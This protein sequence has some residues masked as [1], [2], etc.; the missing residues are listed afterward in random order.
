MAS[1]LRFQHFEVLTRAD[2]SPHLL[3]KGAMGLTY[4][5]FDRNL[6]SFAVV[7]V[8]APEHAGRPEARQRFLQEAQSMARINH[9]N[10]ADVFFLGESAQGVFYAMEFCDG[11]S[12]QEYVEEHGPMNPADVFTLGQQA[13][14]ALRAVQRNNLIHRDIKPSNMILVNDAQ[15]RPQIKL[16]DFGL[17]RD[18]VTNPDLS[19]GGF[20]GTPT[21]ASPEQ[22][23]EQEGLDIRSDIYSLGITLW[24]MLCGRAPFS[25]S[26]FEVMFHHVNT[27]PPWDRLPPL[28]P[29]AVALLRRMIEKSPEERYQNPDSLSEAFQTLLAAGGFAVPSSGLLHFRPRELEGSVLGMSSFEILSESPDSDLT[30]KIF[31]ARDAHDGR[32]IS[33]KYL[34]P[35]IVEKVN[36]LGKIQRHVL[37]LRALKHPNL[38]EILDFEKSESGAQIISEWVYGPSLLSLLKARNHLTLAEA[39]PLLGQL[40]SALD[41]AGSRG[42]GTV[43]T[44]LHQ[45]FLTSPVFGDDPA[46]WPKLLRQPLSSWTDLA[47]KVNPL[48][49]SPAAQDYPTIAQP[50]PAPELTGAPKPLLG[51]FLHLV[52]RLLGGA[53]GSQSGSSAG[54]VSIPGLGA[55]AND[56]IESFG[57]PPFTP[58]KRA[59]TA[60]TVLVGLCQAEGVREPDIYVPPPEP[61]E[62]LMLTRDAALKS[63]PPQQGSTFAR[64][65]T[66][67]GPPSTQ[68][69]KFAPPS[70]SGPGSRFGGP[71]TQ[72]GAPGTQFG[73]QSR[74]GTKYGSSGGGSSAGRISAD[75]E[76]KRKELELQRQR[77]ESEAER[78]KQEEVLE[79]TRA[80]LDEERS[81]LAEAKDEFARQERDRAQRAE[82]ER[83]KLEEERLRLE[84]K[85]GEV[86]VKRREQERLEQEIKLRAQLEFQKFE[87]ERRQRESEWGRQREEIERTLK[88]REEQSLLREQESFRKL[89]Q[90]RERLLAMQ[91]GLEEGKARSQQE[92][93]EALRQQVAALESERQSLADQQAE[94][95]RRLLA[96]N[97]EL[98]TLRQQFETAEREI[99][100][101]YARLT[102]EE[103][104][105]AARR[106]QEMETERQRLADE[107]SQLE[108]HR[109]ELAA[110]RQAGSVESQ[111]ATEQRQ[112]NEAAMAR[113]AEAESRFAEERE[114]LENQRSRREA[115]LA[116]ELAKAKRE[117]E[118]ERGTLARESERA[119]ETGMAELQA[120][121]EAIAATRSQLAAQEA[122]LAAQV[123]QKAQELEE[124]LAGQKRE[125]ENERAALA[126][127][128]E[129]LDAEHE[130]L[131][132]SFTR[133]KAAFASGLEERRRNE[134]A[135]HLQRMRERAAELGRMESDEH[136]RLTALRQEIAAEEARLQSQREDVFTQERL[137]NRMDQEA[138]YQDDEARE[139]LEAEQQR[140]E[141]QRG[142]IEQKILELHKAQK[143]RLVTIV[144]GTIIGVAAACVA[145]FF[146]KGQ[147]IDPAKLKGQEA[148]VKYEGE[149]KSRL[150]TQDWPALL[151]W[152]VETDER[153]QKQETDPVIRTFY[154]SKRGAV[155]N[156]ARQAIDG[157]LAGMENGSTPLPPSGEVE[158]KLRQDLTIVSAWDGLPPERFLLQAKLDLP[159]LTVQ[160]NAGAALTLY[161]DTVAK[162]AAF[163]QNLRPELS[164]TVQGLLDDFLED[165][166]LENRDELFQKLSQLP[167]EA[168]KSVPRTW[169]L[170]H[171]MQAEKMRS[172]KPNAEDYQKS[173]EAINV[174]ATGKT[175]RDFYNKDPEWGKILAAEIPRILDIIKPHREMV[176]GLEDTLRA[177]AELWK[178]DIPYMM[179]AETDVT[180]QK[181][182]DFYKAAIRL[183]G[184][185]KA[186]AIVGGHERQLAK[187]KAAEGDAAGAKALL[188]EAAKLI[189]EAAAGGEPEGLLL[190]AEELRTGIGEEKNL[191]TATQEALKLKELNHPEA[192]Y[193]LGLCYLEQAE[194]TSTPALLDQAR[195]ALEAATRAP[196]SVNTA[197]AW[198]YLAKIHNAKKDNARMISALEAGAKAGDVPSLTLLGLCQI[199]GQHV[200]AN[201]TLG[202]DNLTR[203]ARQGNEQAL[204]YLKKNVARWRAS[205]IPADRDWVERHA[206]LLP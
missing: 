108:Q 40:A 79:A 68:G 12:P 94:L 93:E 83:R 182:V 107:R 23:L 75:Y 105:S 151:H 53:G 184:N 32:I 9:P 169:L 77:L 56:L 191:G 81:A 57:L 15:G 33:L 22:L 46:A 187:Q 137:I 166:A 180:T 63:P 65:G 146:I 136:A 130:R 86:E 188:E 115:S 102:A 203:A 175:T 76:L 41:F 133:E 196:G 31:K 172:T 60:A 171:V 29:P 113:L 176:R 174:A 72:T 3:G 103:E 62:D 114:I 198:Y 153:F 141:G 159:Y 157:I 164:V 158:K 1:P 138:S 45:I 123:A 189:R 92:A 4:K 35:A 48:R 154:Q 97:Q 38:V 144:V 87:E 129:A 131:M 58:E 179:L 104:A 132:E 16:I 74:P 6:L 143:K 5:A 28:P 71:P 67:S 116:E 18:V 24:F 30:G 85:T 140:L 165:H 39:A 61:E 195:K 59:A 112:A 110:E 201:L 90:E 162:N 8:M 11:P 111:A 47:V 88:E 69:S 106:Q 186:K 156:D 145:G 14:E 177:T 2:G 128:R 193:M 119:R 181:K 173:L 194:E 95:D 21:F 54:F 200:P 101:R 149:R 205:K 197:S 64:P 91:Q 99:D 89:R 66:V 163:I 139:K 199:S 17:A 148:W 26:Q 134:E 19:Q 70:Q 43:E 155:L 192:D 160:K 120:E 7:K 126:A 122:E 100:E 190:H 142:E 49:L 82:Q 202:R 42:L 127:R 168:K 10:V 52:Y 73:T 124:R 118:E 135:E 147:L 183:T 121:R 80:M 51:A 167:G 152:S 125:I 206:D 13:A 96:Q 161:T 98:V 27:P 36:V 37:S 78:L 25:G 204:D 185:L 44:D 84:A 55:E 178:T 50:T 20:V 150:T 170:L 117:L 34:H 109:A